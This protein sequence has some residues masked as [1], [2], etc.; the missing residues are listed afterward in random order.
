M[1]RVGTWF[2]ERCSSTLSGGSGFVR[3]SSGISSR[4]SNDPTRLTLSQDCSVRPYSAFRS[5]RQMLGR[6]TSKHR[7][8]LSARFSGRQVSSSKRRTTRTTRRTIE[9]SIERIHRSVRLP[10]RRVT[11]SLLRIRCI[12][13]MNKAIPIKRSTA[14]SSMRSGN[15][16]TATRT[17]RTGKKNNNKRPDPTTGLLIPLPPL[18]EI[19]EIVL[20][21]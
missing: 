3:S 2:R 8:G 12:G 10:V 16:R 19:E 18:T 7:H 21:N 17:T 14:Y 11:T 20:S 4:S 13:F 15:S 5:M 6:W 9:R 1:T